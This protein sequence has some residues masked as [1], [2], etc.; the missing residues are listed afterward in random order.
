MASMYFPIKNHGGIP[1]MVGIDGGISVKHLVKDTRVGKKKTEALPHLIANT[2]DELARG[3]G[4]MIRPIEVAGDVSIIKP[5]K[6]RGLIKN[7][8]GT[9][10]KIT[11]D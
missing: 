9:F 6:A 3:R 4:P 8:K 10:P 11:K 5:G 2:V 7:T 1:N